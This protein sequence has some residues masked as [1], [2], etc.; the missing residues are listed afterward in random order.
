MEFDWKKFSA[1][2]APWR[3]RYVTGINARLT[4]IL[5]DTRLTA[6]ERFWKVE[7]LTRQQAKTL[8]RCLDG[9]SRS[10]MWQHLMEMRAAG[11]IRPEDLA[12]FSE[13]LQHQV[14]DELS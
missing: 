13:E 12:D 11:M 4:Q 9:T 3:E 1:R 5:T 8:Q 2:L 7:E 6:T 14:F 10:K